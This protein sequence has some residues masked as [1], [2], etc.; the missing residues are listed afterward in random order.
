M[1]STKYYFCLFWYI[2]KEFTDTIV[3]VELID[4]YLGNSSLFT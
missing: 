2:R 4:Y 3:T 1:N